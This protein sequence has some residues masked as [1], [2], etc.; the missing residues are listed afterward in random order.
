MNLIEILNEINRQSIDRNDKVAPVEI[1][2][3]MTKGKSG[4]GVYMVEYGSDNKVG[5]LKI[6]DSTSELE[7][8]SKAYEV[9]VKNS[10]HKYIAKMV[11]NFSLNLEGQSELQA[12]L[13]DL[14]GD[15]IYNAETFLDKVIN[16]DELKDA[17]MAKLT[18]FIFTWNKE[19]EKKFLSPI[20]IVRNELSYR[21]MDK[22]FVKAFHELGID[23]DV[24]WISIDGT[25]VILPNPY[26]FFSNEEIWE[27][28][29]VTCLTSYAHGDFQ[30][31]NIMITENKPIIIDFCDVLEDC[32]VFHDIRYLES[33]TLSD[34]ME[35]DTPFQ[36]ELW[37]KICKCVTEQIHEVDIPRGKGM[38]LL[39]QLVPKFRENIKLVVS[40]N[41][42]VLYNPSFYLAGV[43]CGFI[44]MRKIKD[45]V[46]RKAALIY[47]AYNL[48]MF[49]SDEAV[50]KYNPQ[51]DSC[52]TLPWIE[53]NE[54]SCRIKLVSMNEI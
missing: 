7:I 43:S 23:N 54:E 32:N 38:S 24:K 14:A 52:M 8:F 35:F 46:K 51:L 18:K 5:I 47:A 17:V 13:Y 31:N 19:H 22:K 48:K 4:A 9:A 42:N 41:R 49:L 29:K 26:Y 34:Y 25:D 28:L 44:N 36:R 16:E 39:R 10:M 53:L 15:D 3:T 37:M 1:L 21:F 30:G 45:K 12:N 33:I 50:S 40:D 11:A 2:K 6:T 27:G 20:D